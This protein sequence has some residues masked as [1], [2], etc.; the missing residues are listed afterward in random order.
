MIDPN[1][2]REFFQMNLSQSITLKCSRTR[3]FF[4]RPIL[5]EN[6]GNSQLLDWRLPYSRRQ[7]AD[8]QPIP[9]FVMH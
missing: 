8:N 2:F 6:N 1:G 3:A 7:H 9:R 4:E 5:R